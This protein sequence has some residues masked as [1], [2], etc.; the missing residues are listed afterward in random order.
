MSK[1]EFGCHGNSPRSTQGALK[2]GSGEISLFTNEV[3]AHWTSHLHAFNYGGEAGW[4]IPAH[5]AYA[6]PPPPPLM[7]SSIIVATLRRGKKRISIRWAESSAQHLFVWRLCLGSF[8]LAQWDTIY[9]FMHEFLFVSQQRIYSPYYAYKYVLQ[10]SHT[11]WLNIP[12]LYMLC[13]SDR[14]I[15]SRHTLF[16]CIILA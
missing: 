9:V 1:Q 12:L 16:H 3:P 2:N 15:V 13:L 8:H 6:P 7:R 11:L 14:L 4:E 10:Q 5:S